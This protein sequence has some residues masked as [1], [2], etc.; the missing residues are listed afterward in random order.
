MVRLLCIQFQAQWSVAH[1]W[2]N[3]LLLESPTETSSIKWHRSRTLQIQTWKRFGSFFLWI[4]KAFVPRSCFHCIRS[5]SCT[6]AHH[7]PRNCS[8]GKMQ[9]VTYNLTVKNKSCTMNARKAKRILKFQLSNHSNGKARLF[10]DAKAG[11]ALDLSMAKVSEWLP[12]W[13]LGQG[14][15]LQFLGGNGSQ[16]LIQGSQSKERREWIER[17]IH[18]IQKMESRSCLFLHSWVVAPIPCRAQLLSRCFK[19]VFW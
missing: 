13:E 14:R 1:D 8:S 2:S 15:S 16:G 11:A 12:R 9:F 6:L 7:S 18:Y 17:R 10:W 19:S 5:G 4:R 3:R